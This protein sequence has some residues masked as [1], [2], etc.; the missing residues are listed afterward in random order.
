MPYSQSAIWKWVTSILFPLINVYNTPLMTKYFSVAEV[1]ASSPSYP[2]NKIIA[3]FTE[4]DSTD[5]EKP[6]LLRT[7]VF[8]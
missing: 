8:G 6:V 3:I 1:I 5:H 4:T 7:K 2:G